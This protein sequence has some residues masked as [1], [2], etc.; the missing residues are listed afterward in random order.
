MS[1]V[2]EEFGVDVLR[3]SENAGPTG[4]EVRM[5]QEIE[6]LRMAVAMT[7]MSL[8]A[9]RRDYIATVCLSAIIL[10]QD[11]PGSVDD[12]ARD[13]IRYADALI[14][15]FDKEAISSWIDKEDKP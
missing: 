14:V 5:A 12:C 11:C 1:K 2:Y 15:R 6:R 3:D 8:R 13:A 4:A 7:E 9:Q 10:R